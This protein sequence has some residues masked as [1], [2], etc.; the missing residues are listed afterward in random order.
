M[1][2]ITDAWTLSGLMHCG[3]FQAIYDAQRLVLWENRMGTKKLGFFRKT[4]CFSPGY[5]SKIMKKSCLGGIRDSHH[6]RSSPVNNLVIFYCSFYPGVNI[7]A[8]S[9]RTGIFNDE[10]L[11]WRSTVDEIVISGEKMIDSRL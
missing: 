6:I 5:S 8:S 7:F 2:L 4:S 10:F 3:G 1:Q 9:M 11:V